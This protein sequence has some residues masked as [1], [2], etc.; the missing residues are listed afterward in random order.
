MAIELNENVEA[1]LL[2]VKVS[3]KLSKED[4]INVVPEKNHGKAPYVLSEVENELGVP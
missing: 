2:E 1:K 3:G 4:Y